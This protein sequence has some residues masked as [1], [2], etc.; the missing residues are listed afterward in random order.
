MGL[1]EEH[2]HQAAKDAYEQDKAG[3]DEHNGWLRDAKRELAGYGVSPQQIARVERGGGDPAELK[4]MDVAADAFFKRRPDLLQPGENPADGL[5]RLLVEGNRQPASLED[6]Y[7][8]AVEHLAAMKEAS[9]VNSPE[10]AALAE[11]ARR[12]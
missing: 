3:A 9:R 6:H 1:N 4:G 8:L 11:A 12:Q 7:Q 5:A 10:E 2:V